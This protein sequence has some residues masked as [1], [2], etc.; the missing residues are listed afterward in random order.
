MSGATK[1]V[2]VEPGAAAAVRGALESCVA[3]GGIAVFPSDGLYGL[4]CDPLNEAAIGRIHRL[5]GRDEG[6]SSAVM[7]FSP[8]AMRE[9]LA[10]LGPRT[11]AA[12]SAL[13]PGPVTLIVANHGHRYPLACR[14]D[15]DRLGVRLISGPLAGAMCPIFQTSANVS[16][17]FA[18][19]SLGEVPAEIVAGADLAIDAGTLPGVPSTVIDI[20]T[21]EED[22]SW[23]VLRDGALSAGDLASALA[24]VGLG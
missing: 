7:Y 17:R 13:L 8:L 18:P 21:I 24:G 3:A 22:G 23:E 4:A 14:E 5:K 6:K 19:A 2:K 20:A 15:I 11:A 1:I 10:G 9:L 12:I 16:G